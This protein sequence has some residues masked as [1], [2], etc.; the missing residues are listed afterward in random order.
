LLLFL[1]GCGK[2]APE[3]SSSNSAQRLPNLDQRMKAWEDA[4]PR[5][6]QEIITR[7]EEQLAGRTCVRN[8]ARWQRLFSYHYNPQTKLLD[9]GTIDF[10]FKEAGRFGIKAGRQITAPDA[11]MTVDDTPI[12][13]VWGRYSVATNQI[14]IEFC[15]NNEGETPDETE[16]ASGN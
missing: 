15:G 12:Q 16:S 2:A 14:T 3:Q 1:L 8:L 7:I 10:H 4:Q 6:P 9:R 13:M 5:P 11:W